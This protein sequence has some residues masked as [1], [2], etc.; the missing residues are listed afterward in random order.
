MRVSP[1]ESALTLV[2]ATAELLPDS[3]LIWMKVAVASLVL[4]G[5]LTI[6]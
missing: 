6:H 3:S 4:S 1:C 2:T 5:F